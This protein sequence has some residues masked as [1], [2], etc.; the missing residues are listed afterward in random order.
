M[1]FKNNTQD[2]LSKLLGTPD[3]ETQ[4]ERVKRLL[5]APVVELV[6]RLDGRN[7]RVTFS[8]MGGEVP[9]AVVY[10][11]LDVCRR[12][13]HQLELQAAAQH[14]GQAGGGAPAPAD[15]V[16]EGAAEK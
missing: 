9:P 14:A 12:Q 2:E 10:E 7:N 11:M 8:V 13:V 5:A 4:V 6:I 15:G 3:R 1:K 16:D